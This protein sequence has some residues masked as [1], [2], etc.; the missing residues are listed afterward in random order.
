[1][2]HA[3]RQMRDHM[4]PAIKPALQ[5]LEKTWY[6]TLVEVRGHGSDSAYRVT[7]EMINRVARAAEENN[8]TIMEHDSKWRIGA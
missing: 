4:L 3:Y 7:P 2:K 8:R 1:M 5:Y 6:E